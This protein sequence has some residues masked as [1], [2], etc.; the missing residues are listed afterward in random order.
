MSC[1]VVWVCDH[2]GKE[3]DT[4]NDYSE[5]ELG[6][7]GSWEK[8]DLCKKCYEEIRKTILDFCGKEVNG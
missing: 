7:I 3:L 1:K 5:T 4:M 8:A 6:G 2:C